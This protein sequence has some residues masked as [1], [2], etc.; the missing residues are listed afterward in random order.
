MSSV[1]K[2]S[3]MEDLR[4]LDSC[5]PVPSVA[6]SASLPSEWWRINTPLKWVKWEFFLRDHPDR[7]FARYI[8][9]GLRNGFRIGFE[10]TRHACTPAKRNMMSALQHPSVIDAYIK[11]ECDAGTLPRWCW[12]WEGGWNWRKWTFAQHTGWYLST[13]VTGGCTDVTRSTSMR[14]C[15][16]GLDQH[17]RY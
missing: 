14:R 7:D 9:E 11:E 6:A 5:R 4:K 8:I 13:Q 15:P 2:Y 16:L 1:G 17:Q 10:Y 12:P 3:Y